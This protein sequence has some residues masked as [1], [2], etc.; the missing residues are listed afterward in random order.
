MKRLSNNTDPY[1]E[2]YREGRMKEEALL[3]PLL[4]VPHPVT[5][6]LTLGSDLAS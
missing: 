6:A 2:P 3:G 4:E 5:L 1:T